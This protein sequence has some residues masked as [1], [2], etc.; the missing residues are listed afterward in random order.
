MANARS[1]TTEVLICL[2]QQQR[3][4][5]SSKCH[6]TESKQDTALIALKKMY[7]FNIFC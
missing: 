1:F 4:A 3:L 2:I 6:S 5:S 7:A